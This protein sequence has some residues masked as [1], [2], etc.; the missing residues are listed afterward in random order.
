[1][2]PLLITGFGPFPGIPKNPS[3][4]I[5]RL[6]ARHPRLKRQGIEVALRLIPT[7]Y[8]VAEDLVP[9]LVAEI[10]PVAVLMFGVAGRRRHVSIETRAV[11]RVSILH[12]DAAGRLPTAL[13]LSKGAAWALPGRAPFA[14]M[15]V[16]SGRAG[17]P[18]RAS[19]TAGTYLC[20]FSYRRMLETLPANRPCL[21]VHIPPLKGP[22]GHARMLAAALAL[23]DL[24]LRFRPAVAVPP[25]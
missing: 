7:E 12:P 1:M 8:A 4:T 3:A 14:R 22:R 2:G 17:P 19:R 5:A 6:L 21:F 20:N 24:L 11:N 16:A 15:V 25:A 13:T 10:D 9:R 18:T 23:P